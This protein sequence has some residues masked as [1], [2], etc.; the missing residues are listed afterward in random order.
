MKTRRLIASV[1]F[2]AVG[3]TTAAS[4]QAPAVGVK[5]TP[6]TYIRAETDRQ[7][8]GIVETAGGV[9]RLFHLRSPTPLDKQNAARM[10]RDT[11]YSMGVVDTAKR[12]TITVPEIPKDRYVSVYLVDNDHYCPLVIYASGTH[13][14]PRDTKYLGVVVRIQ[15]FDPKNPDEIALINALQDRFVITAGSADPLPDF[16]WDLASLKALTVQYEQEAA[17]YSSF[18]GMMGPRGRV[19]GN[20]RHVAAAAG[21]GLFPEWDA[22]Y[23]NY[24]GGSHDPRVCYKTTYTVPENKAFWSVTVYGSDGYLKSDNSIVNASTVKFNSDGTLTLYFGSKDVCG[25]MPNRMDVSAGWIYVMRIY[26][27]GPSV[28]NGQYKLPAVVSQK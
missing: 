9:N 21:W 1:V 14:L 24:S 20:T 2:G 12:A 4:G 27:P 16:R 15:V 23:L 25:D 10:N 28:L 7:F 13:A 5:V 8:S 6:A 11:L 19:D 22:T 18:K 17:S 3:F 26:R